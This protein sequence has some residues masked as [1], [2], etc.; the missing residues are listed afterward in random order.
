MKA[1][2]FT[3]R[4]GAGKTTLVERL[5]QRFTAEGL[6]VSAIKHAH[7]GFDMDTPGKDS[8]RFREAGADQVLVGSPRRWALLTECRAAA[9]GAGSAADADAMSR[10]RPDPLE[11][12]LAR[13][14]P[15]DLVLVE[16]FR[17]QK[18]VPSIHVHR[19]APGR[20][21]LTAPDA[22]ACA[23]ACNEP[24]DLRERFAPMPVLALDDVAAVSEFV[25]E[26]LALGPASRFAL[27]RA[28]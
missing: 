1:I 8:W 2:A 20:E 14:D 7:H 18:L 22:G 12:M 21:A 10:P 5:V 24:G 13:L 6:R 26:C 16:G 3:G 28:R 4:S 23:I 17:G 27:R 25:R 15:C 11:D 19:V 9:P